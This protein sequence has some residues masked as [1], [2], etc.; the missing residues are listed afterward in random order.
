MIESFSYKSS[1][2][3]IY[4]KWESFTLFYTANWNVTEAVT[5]SE[6]W[7]K[8]ISKWDTVSH[9]QVQVQVD[10]FSPRIGK[11]LYD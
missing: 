10:Q 2:I 4:Q 8:I 9:V 6:W 3:D 7:D 11:Y 1:I 5:Y